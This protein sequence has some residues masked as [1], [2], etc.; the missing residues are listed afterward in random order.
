MLHLYMYDMIL[1]YIYA[2]IYAHLCIY[3]YI[4][5]TTL[6]SLDPITFATAKIYIIKNQKRIKKMSFL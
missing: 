4:Y 2:R 3:I 5:K 1:D 6:L